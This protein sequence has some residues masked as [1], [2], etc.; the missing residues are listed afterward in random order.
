MKKR[1]AALLAFAMTLSMT[2]CTQGQAE[3]TPTPTPPASKEPVQEARFTPGTYEATIS[4]VGGPLTVSVEV[5]ENTIKAI[6][7]TELNDTP[8]IGEAAVDQ[9][10][11]DM[12]ANQTANV[13]AATGATLTSFSFR[14]AV[15]DALKK[16]G[17]AP[18]E[19]ASFAA[20]AQTDM[21][22]D[23]VVVGGGMA[24]LSAALA[25]ADHGVKVVLLEKSA[26]LGGIMLVSDQSSLVTGFE[27][28]YDYWN[29]AV[30]QVIAMG[31]P[32][33][34]S[35]ANGRRSM[36]APSNPEPNLTARFTKSF[37]EVAA[38][39]GI[40]IMTSTPAVDL[41]IDGGK[42]TGVVAQPR[43]QE[44]F[45]ITAGSVV[46]ATGGFSGNAEL[47]AQY[48]PYASG[49]RY[50]GVGGAKGD[51]LAWVEPLNAKLVGMDAEFCS[52]YSVNPSTGFNA[53]YASGAHYYVRADGTWISEDTSYNTGSQR[54][55]TEI[56]SETYY[57]I[58]PTPSGKNSYERLV[59]AG[60]SQKFNT[61]EEIAKELDM[62]KLLET[63]EAN[64]FPKEGPYY[65]GKAVAGIYG[66]YG[67]LATDINGHV[68]NESDE[69]IPGLY[70]AGE[71]LG[72]RCYQSTGS[73]MGGI[74]VAFANGNLAGNAAATDIAK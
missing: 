9:L 51:A 60:T 33:E 35:E 71:V 38:K 73:Y 66:T 30:E 63:A 59:L 18:S 41:I 14:S 17:G 26:Y 48:Y 24:G 7:V 68:L 25:A 6:T 34:N 67:G 64:N 49:A 61:L 40:Q 52:F 2:A 27:P 23:V 13:D 70:A 5:D 57:S 1:I 4:S 11:A 69:V 15:T 55:Y 45:K 19:K 42:V 74:G 58:T 21:D 31:M 53:Q 32:L 37:Q 8:I 36:S 46:L 72:S 3:S 43:G 44:T 54:V 10:T 56:G 29:G 62:P 39:Y 28:T 65:V 12:L 50:V 22:A 47:V 20:P 16:A